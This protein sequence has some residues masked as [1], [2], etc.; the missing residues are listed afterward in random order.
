M[1]LQLSFRQNS[2]SSHKTQRESKISLKV[3]LNSCR[4]SIHSFTIHFL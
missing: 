2:S 4:T 3:W 1:F